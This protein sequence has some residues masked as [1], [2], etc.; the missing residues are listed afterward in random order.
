MWKMRLLC[1]ALWQD[2]FRLEIKLYF[3][4]VAFLRFKIVAFTFA[5]SDRADKVTKKVFVCQSEGKWGQILILIDSRF[6]SPLPL[7]SLSFSLSLCLSFCAMKERK[8]IVEKNK[9]KLLPPRATTNYVTSLGRKIGIKKTESEFKKNG[10]GTKKNSRDLQPRH[11]LSE[12]NYL[13]LAGFTE[14]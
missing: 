6:S 4:L 13:R 8:E 10:I 11:L 5:K 3:I 2:F 9:T 14:D 12:L 7:L 1:N